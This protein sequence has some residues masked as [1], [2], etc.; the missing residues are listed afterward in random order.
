MNNRV[1]IIEVEIKLYAAHSLKDKRKLRQK[2]VDKIKAAHNISIAETDHQELWD[3]LGL[4][5]AYVAIG[6]QAAELKAERLADYLAS[7]L[8][9]DGTGELLAY[10]PVIV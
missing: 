9:I 8:E 1:L 2:I 3:L 7:L 10:N 4:T 5:I 6:Q